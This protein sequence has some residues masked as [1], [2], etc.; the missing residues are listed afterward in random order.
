[1]TASTSL[2][3]ILIIGLKLQFD[4]LITARIHECGTRRMLDHHLET[5]GA[6]LLMYVAIHVVF[7]LASFEQAVETLEALMRDILHVSVA[8]ARRVGEQDIEVALTL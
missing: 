3:A 1:M 5:V 8:S 7:R 2:S 6:V 4:Q